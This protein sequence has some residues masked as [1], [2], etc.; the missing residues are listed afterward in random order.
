MEPLNVSVLIA[1]KNEEKNIEGAIRSVEWA[2][3]VTLIDSGSTDSTC[4][5]AQSLGS[6]VCQFHYNGMWP[7]KR[8]W[9]LKN[10]TIRNPWVLVLD[11]DERVSPELRKD[12]EWAIRQDEY[13]GFYIKWQFYFLGKW[14]KY[15]WSHGWMLRLFRLGKGV[16]EDLGM[17]DEGG[18]D[19]E[20]HENIVVDGKCSKLKGHLIHKSNENLSYWIEKQ[21]SFSDWNA[22]R[23]L[24][25]VNQGIP[26]IS[27][28]FSSDPGKQRKWLKAIFLRLPLKS[29]LMFI[30]LYVIK[31]GFLDG[32]AGYH[33]CALRAFH[34]GQINAKIF[35]LKNVIKNSEK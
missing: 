17:R 29:F 32:L 3:Q 4:E 24:T 26:P 35:E 23:R 16:Y 10:V 1:T 33:F 7:K 15:S 11:A 9:A 27:S 13:D 22:R 34:E 12:I 21:N 8:N 2:D 19:V 6:E 28:V 30:Y 31:M 18:W 14:M 20:V 5:I 25:Q